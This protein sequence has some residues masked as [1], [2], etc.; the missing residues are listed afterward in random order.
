MD[1]QQIAG[2]MMEYN[3]SL[4]DST[5][6]TISTIQDQS[7][8]MLTAFMEKAA[9]LPDDGKKVIADWLSTYR[10]GR[11]DIKA[12]ADDKYEKVASYFMKNETAG[13]A[14]MQK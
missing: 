14:R 12:A 10:K 6:K 9:W 7:E 2:K 8:K 5:F 11:E 13:S 1:Q 4:F 3:K